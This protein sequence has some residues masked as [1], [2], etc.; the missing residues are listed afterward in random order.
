[1]AIYLNKDTKIIVQGITGTVGKVQSQLAIEY[2]T[3]IV[4]G[5]VPGKGGKTI[6]NLPVYDTVREAVDE[7]G[8]NAS[9]I[10]APAKAVKSAAEEA[11]MAGLKLIVIITE[12]VPISDTL[13]IRALAREKEVVVIGPNCPGLL[14]PKIGKMGIIP[15]HAP[16]PGHIGIISRSGTLAFEATANLTAAGIG[17][18]TIVGIGGDP[19]PC[20]SMMEVLAAFEEDSNT[21]GVVIIGEVGGSAEESASL[22]IKKYMT[23]PVFAFIAG[24][25]AP[26]GKKM[27]HAGAIIKGSSGTPKSKIEALSS[28]GVKIA[29]SPIELPKL[30]FESNIV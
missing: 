8:A 29:S 25:T 30:I 21:K 5:V 17:Q 27:G 15:G 3:N 23:K 28:A 9:V 6:L 1:M 12:H 19:V 24:V 4:C 20:T 10:Y 7:K 16:S 22:Y 26:P 11:I 14:T 2:G 13:K 18:S